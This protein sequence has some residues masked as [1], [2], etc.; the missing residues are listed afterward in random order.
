MVD[1]RVPCLAAGRGPWAIACRA[2]RDARLTHLQVG[3]LGQRDGH[4]RA[5]DL[6]LVHM[7]DGAIGGLLRVIFEHSPWACICAEQAETHESAIV[8]K[9]VV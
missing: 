1:G 5:I 9:N 6:P 4:M 3:P 7:R 8:H 2:G